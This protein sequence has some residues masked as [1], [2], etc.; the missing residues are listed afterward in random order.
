[1]FLRDL[2]IGTKVWIHASYKGNSMEFETSVVDVQNAVVYLDAVYYESVRIGFHNDKVKYSIIAMISNKLY[3]FK[4]ATVESNTDIDSLIACTCSIES[5]LCNR[6]RTPRFDIDKPCVFS[7]GDNRKA[8]E[9]IL[10]DVSMTGFSV[11]SKDHVDI[12]DEV[13]VA[14]IPTGANRQIML[15]AKV[16]RKEELRKNDYLYG[17]NLINENSQ[18]NAY[19]MDIQR[20]RRKVELSRL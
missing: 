8:V 14:V 15:S 9:A 7:L 12:G 18:F 3:K 13:R 16:V 19:I 5:E 1:M 10:H 2:K 6:R 20:K 11:L 17:C 4:N